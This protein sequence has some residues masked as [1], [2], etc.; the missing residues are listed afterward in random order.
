ML[1]KREYTPTNSI[2]MISGS[3]VLIHSF[4]IPAVKSVPLPL[5]TIA[6]HSPSTAKLSKH[7][8]ISLK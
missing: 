6:L 4:L 8:L 2:G 1:T 7:C 3:H 5:K